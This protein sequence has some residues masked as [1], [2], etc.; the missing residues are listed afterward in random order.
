MMHNE[1]EISQAERRRIM[2]EELRAKGTLR[3]MAEADNDLRGGRYR[4]QAKKIGAD[5]IDTIKTVL[6]VPAPAGW[7][8]LWSGDPPEPPLGYSVEDHEP[9]GEPH[10]IKASSPSVISRRDGG[11][12]DGSASDGTPEVRPVTRPSEER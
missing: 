3:A 9:V 6:K 7:P 12:G 11:V 8:S 5:F 4:M 2:A 1:D 10:E